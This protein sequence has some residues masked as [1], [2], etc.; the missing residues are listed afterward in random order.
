MR[1]VLSTAEMRAADAATMRTVPHEVLV[2][3]AGLAA[4][5]GAVQL[6]PRVYGTSVAVLCGPG[7]NGAD[8]RVA[9]RHLA[10][11]GAV[12]RVLETTAMPPRVDGAALVVDAAFGTGLSRAWDA[13]FVDP[14]VAVL[15][16]DLPSGVDPDSGST[17]GEALQA[18]RTVAMGALKRGHLLADGARLSGE[19][20]VATLGIEVTEFACALVEDDDLDA[21]PPLKRDDHKWRRAVVVVAGAPGM[22]GAPALACDGALAVQ[23]GMVLLC[24]PDVPRRRE[25]PWPRE[26]VRLASSAE[27]VEK[28]VIDALDRARALVI[29]PGLGR[30]ARLQ[31][32]VVDIVRA[33]R[34]PIV[35]DADA[36]HLVD[37]DLLAARQERGGSPLVLTPHDGEYAALF[38]APPGPD[39]FAA[40][41]RAAART[42]CTVLLKGPTTVV[43]STAPPPGVPGVLAVTSGTPDLATPGSGDVLAGVIG[44]LLARGVPAHLAAALGAH[45]HG[46]AGASLG[47]ACR[48]TAL[49]DAIASILAGRAARRVGA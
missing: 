12:V 17:S 33:T 34:E 23:A 26:V 38:G 22:L 2:E 48:A 4:A 42:G 5:L 40:A 19:I 37:P 13:P 36:L 7:A 25:G 8:G 43:A 31:R 39:R 11:R 46:L 30:S 47:P 18:R 28:V 24:A 1:P 6:V 27:D 16:V 49:P 45:V 21:I 41:Q 44:G 29:G 15:A 10:A 14:A 35:L 20:R 9:A 32:A 3:R